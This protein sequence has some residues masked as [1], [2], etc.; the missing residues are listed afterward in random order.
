MCKFP[1]PCI[2][3]ESS[4]LALATGNQKSDKQV[5]RGTAALQSDTTTMDVRDAGAWAPQVVP[6][7]P[8]GTTTTILSHPLTCKC[9]GLLPTTLILTIDSLGSH[10]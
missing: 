2:C 8:T 10:D 9:M 7:L 1:F 5:R 6:V 4:G 3:S